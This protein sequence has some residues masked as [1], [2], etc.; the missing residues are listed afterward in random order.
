MASA[1]KKYVIFEVASINEPK[2][3]FSGNRTD[4]LEQN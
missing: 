1:K 2:K 3:G 4:Y